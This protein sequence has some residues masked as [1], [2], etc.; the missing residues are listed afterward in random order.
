[1]NGNKYQKFKQIKFAYAAAFL[2]F[3]PQW[4]QKALNQAGLYSR[5]SIIHTHTHTNRYGYT[6]KGVYVCKVR[7]EFKAQ[8]ANVIFLNSFTVNYE[9]SKLEY[10]RL[11]KRY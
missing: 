8:L 1:M 9:K 6:E 11:T 2:R 10:N 4:T 7:L 5:S 3:A